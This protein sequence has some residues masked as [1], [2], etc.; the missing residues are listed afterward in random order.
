M[1]ASPRRCDTNRPA[2]ETFGNARLKGDFPM[3]T[4]RANNVTINYER[5]GAGDPLVLIP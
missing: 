3:A 2:A 4:I 5:Q 1:M